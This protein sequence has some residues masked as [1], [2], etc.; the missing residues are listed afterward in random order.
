MK[1]FNVIIQSWYDASYEG[2]IS[3]NYSKLVFAEDE[4]QAISFVN[5]DLEKFV[6][7]SLIFQK[8][9]SIAV[10]AYEVDSTISSKKRK[11]QYYKW[12]TAL[13]KLA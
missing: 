1:L 13:G 10:S 4:N 3:R 12:I 6:D 8:E 5:E 2:K 7:K 9:N 11:T